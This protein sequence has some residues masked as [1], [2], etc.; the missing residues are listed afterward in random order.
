MQAPKRV[1]VLGIGIS[2][3]TMTQALAIIEEWIAQREAH[4]VCVTSVHGVMES[5]R[6]E[7]L[8]CIHNAAG[9]LSSPKPEEIA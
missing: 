3:I 2:A 6:D 1:N 8:R 7:N 9:R 4:Y 5:Q